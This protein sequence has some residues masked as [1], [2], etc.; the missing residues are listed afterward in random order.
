MVLKLIIFDKM[1]YPPPWALGDREGRPKPK[2]FIFSLYVFE[3]FS[4]SN[5]F[6][7]LPTLGRQILA[8]T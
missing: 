1:P 5:E 2:F 3:H 7:S 4:D 8:P 6:G